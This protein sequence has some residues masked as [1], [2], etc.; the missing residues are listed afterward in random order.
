MQKEVLGCFLH[1]LPVATEVTVMSS[2]VDSSL[3]PYLWAV[4]MIWTLFGL[5]RK[6]ERYLTG[7]PWYI[8]Y[9]ISLISTYGLHISR[10]CPF[11]AENGH[12][13]VD[14]K[15]VTII[16]KWWQNWYL[17][18]RLIIWNDLL[19]EKSEPKRRI[20]KLNQINFNTVL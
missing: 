18:I 8:R 3:Y 1:S 6:S 12:C 2:W 16:A 4:R 13:D 14:I 20:L 19:F 15:S 10:N 11:L 7:F 17:E 9:R 5:G